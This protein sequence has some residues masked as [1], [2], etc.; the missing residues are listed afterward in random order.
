MHSAHSERNYGY[1]KMQQLMLGTGAAV[2][3]VTD[4]DLM[5]DNLIN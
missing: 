4:P 1:L 2:W 5:Q 3:W